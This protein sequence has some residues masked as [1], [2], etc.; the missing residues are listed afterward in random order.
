MWHFRGLTRNLECLKGLRSST[1]ND[2]YTTTTITI[3]MSA[4]ASASALR[5]ILT[6]STNPAILPIAPRTTGNKVP[7]SLHK[8]RRT[9]R[10]NVVRQDWHISVPAAFTAPQSQSQSDA[11]AQVAVPTKESVVVRGV[12]M[13]MR[14]RKDVEK[15]GGLEGLLVS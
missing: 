14:R 9:W 7:K 1:A 5:N 11:Y 12:K 8:T 10:P 4:T 2:R 15:A 6:R 13:Q 3:T